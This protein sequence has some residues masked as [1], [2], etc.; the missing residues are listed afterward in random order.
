MKTITSEKFVFIK[1]IQE[2]G[3]DWRRTKYTQTVQEIYQLVFRSLSSISFREMSVMT[4]AMMMVTMATIK[5]IRM[6]TN[7]ITRTIANF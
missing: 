6:M 7:T 3:F 2:I 4:M 1:E 5:T